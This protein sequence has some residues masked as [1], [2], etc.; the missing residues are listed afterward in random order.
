LLE[1]FQ[2][3]ISALFLGCQPPAMNTILIDG[4]GDITLSW[5]GKQHGESASVNSETV[6]DWLSRLEGLCA[7]YKDED[8]F[9]TDETGLLGVIYR[10][11]LGC[12]LSI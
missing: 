2:N 9:N 4:G 8:I 7:N 11:K 1:W 6:N 3:V 12:H 10:S 5:H